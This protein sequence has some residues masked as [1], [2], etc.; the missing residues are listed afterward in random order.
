MKTKVWMTIL[1]CA[2][3]CLTCWTATAEEAA[4]A[5]A[6]AE[7]AGGPKTVLSQ[8]DLSD[9]DAVVFLG[10]SITHQCLYTQYVENF[11]YTRFPSLHLHFHNA[12]VGGDRAADA[13]ARFD[14]DVAAFKPRYV[15]LLLGMNDGG[16]RDFDKATFDTYQKD[17]S[18]LLDRIA[19]IGAVA[20]P[21]TPTMHDSRAARLRNKGAEPRDTYYNGVLALYGAWL[22]EVAQVRGLGFVDMYSPL[23]Q[24]TFAQRKTDPA[25]TL[26]QD[27]VHPD[28]PGQVV[29]A[30]ALV[31]DICPRGVVSSITIQEKAGKLGAVAANAKIADFQADGDGVCFTCTANALPWVVSANAQPGCKLVSL[32]H[33]YSMEAFTARNLKPGKYELKID[34]QS[35]G[36]W[37]EAQLAFRLELEGNDKTPQY[38]QAMQVALLNQERNEK[39]VHPL[40]DLWLQLKVRRRQMAQ[41]DPNDASQ[42]AARKEQFEKWFA[43]EFQPGVAKLQ[44]LAKDYETRIYQLNQ[45]VARKYELLP[46]K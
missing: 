15:T 38:Q 18:A 46:V 1:L 5:A 36:T 4:K 28:A 8:M 3:A 33:R 7:T 40:R 42:S 9:G 44:A 17:M 23:N 11:Y 30:A 19:E 34:G 31:G 35:V 27:A 26:I 2:A 43:D 41:Q 39:A 32:G 21:M 25:F 13:L 6:A 24:L 16:Y 20:I 29:M 37:T 10:D 12:G 22:R 14:D 45:P